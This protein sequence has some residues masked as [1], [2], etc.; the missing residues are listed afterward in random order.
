MIHAG[1]EP[2]VVLH[3]LIER[4]ALVIHCQAPVA[5]PVKRHC[6]AAVRNDQLQRREIL[7]QISHDEL[8]ECS[9]VGIDVV[10]AGAVKARIARGADVHHRRH[11]KLHHLFIKFVPPPIGQRRCG[12]IPA[13]RIRI[14]IA[15]DKTELL[16]AALQLPDAA[17]RRNA[18]RLRQLAHADEIV[19]IERA[20]AIDH[21]V[22]QLRPGQAHVVI[23]DVMAHAHGTRG[24]DGDIGAALTLELE[25]RAFET[26]ADFVVGNFER[27]LGGL[28]YRV[29]HMIHLL[30]APPQQVF[31][32]GRVVAV[33]IDDHGTVAVVRIGA[34]NS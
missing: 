30:L 16:H 26:L 7:E 5:T 3:H 17:V 12:P 9:G 15:A 22:A 11:V 31:R 18:W 25:L 34:Q 28:F 20:D 32:L 24:E 2:N 19:R 29:F 23:A 14:E 27:R 33:A 1:V 6:A 4:R 13:R 10:G 21:L 8:H